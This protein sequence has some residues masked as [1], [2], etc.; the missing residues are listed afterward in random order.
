[1]AFRPRLSTGLVFSLFVV[2]SLYAQQQKD[3][4]FVYI[5]GILQTTRNVCFGSLAVIKDDTSLMS[6]FG[7]IA[8][9]Q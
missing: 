4:L 8:D 1:M 9:V 2:L 6:A 5:T 7:R 3:A